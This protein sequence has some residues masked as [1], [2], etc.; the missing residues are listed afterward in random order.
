MNKPQL[1]LA[2][3]LLD[4]ILP[5]LFRDQC[6]HPNLEES[7]WLDDG[8]CMIAFNCPNCCFFGCYPVHADPKTWLGS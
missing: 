5:G 1:N 2:Q 6:T 7:R 4:S 3:R 8:A